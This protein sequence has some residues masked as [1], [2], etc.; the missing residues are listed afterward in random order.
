MGKVQMRDLMWEF[1]WLRC[2][3][4]LT[5]KV[6]ET[7]LRDNENR[8]VRA[9]YLNFSKD[10]DTYL[11]SQGSLWVGKRKE[12]KIK[13]SKPTWRTTKKIVDL[14]LPTPPSPSTTSL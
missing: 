5:N 2:R 11:N 10:E 13:M 4:L 14:T 8:C 7:K 3:W 6:I 1:A 12:E 9:R